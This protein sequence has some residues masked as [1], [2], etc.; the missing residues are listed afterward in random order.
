MHA[1]AKQLRE[2]LV[3]LRSHTCVV[4]GNHDFFTARGSVDVYADGGWLKTLRGRG[5]VVAVPGD[6][7]EFGGLRIA[8][9]GWLQVPDLNRP[10]DVLITHAP[11]SGCQC[12]AGA[13]GIDVGDPDLWPAV[14]EYP[15]TLVVTGHIHRPRKLACTWPPIDPTSLILVTGCDEQSPTPAHWV[16]DTDSKVAIHSGGEKVRWYDDD[17]DACFAH[18]TARSRGIEDE[19]LAEEGGAADDAEF[20]TALGCSVPELLARAEAHEVFCIWH[21]NR[22]HWPRWQLHE[23]K[24]LPGLRDALIVLAEKQANDFSV[25]LFFLCPTDA[26]YFSNDEDLDVREN[27]SPLS[28]L[29]RCRSCGVPL[30]VQHAQRFGEHGAL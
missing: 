17:P 26:L 11:P 2:W 3:S 24:P 15:P 8:C 22:R 27:D 13:E 7:F 5:N 21:N 29:R 4:D 20:A 23:G 1:Q 25:A 28:L 9:N 16:I 19:T 30:V 12:A 18:V 10:V 14:Q 6:V